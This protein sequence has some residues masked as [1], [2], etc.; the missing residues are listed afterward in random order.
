M[1]VFLKEQVLQEVGKQQNQGT[2]FLKAA[3]LGR[4]KAQAQGSWQPVLRGRI[5]EAAEDR[6][7]LAC[8]SRVG[9]SRR[10]KVHCLLNCRGCHSPTVYTKPCQ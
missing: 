4:R 1:R 8:S 9:G 5:E 7:E 6:G 2:W 10:R 3:G